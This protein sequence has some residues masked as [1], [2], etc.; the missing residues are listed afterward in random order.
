MSIDRHVY[1]AL[2]VVCVVCACWLGAASSVAQAQTLELDAGSIA[3]R[4]NAELDDAPLDLEPGHVLLEIAALE[5]ARESISIGGITALQW[6]SIAVMIAGGVTFAVYG[7]L[8][9]VAALAD[10]DRGASEAITI[11]AVVASV[12]IPLGV[13]GLCL[14][15]LDEGLHR[16]RALDG[17]ITRLRRA[18]RHRVELAPGLLRVVF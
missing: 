17:R 18:S 12:A 10:N 15:E 6:T 16:R 5:A 2:L 14:A 8:A 9:G 1:G 13:L 11:G 4:T 3:A 7:L